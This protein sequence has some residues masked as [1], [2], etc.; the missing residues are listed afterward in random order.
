MVITGANDTIQK[1]LR[2]QIATSFT[3]VRVLGGIVGGDSS[4]KKNTTTGTT[5]TSGTTGT[6]NTTGTS[7]S[8]SSTK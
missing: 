2:D 4:T 6:T 8:S 7:D 1:E 5:G 3:P